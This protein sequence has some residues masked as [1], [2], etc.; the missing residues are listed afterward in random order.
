M[1]N[2]REIGPLGSILLHSPCFKILTL[3]P[4]LNRR[5]NYRK[6]MYHSAKLGGLLGHYTDLV[7]DTL[8]FITILNINGGVKPL[9]EFPTKFTSI[10]VIFLWSSI[11]LPLLISSIHLAKNNY[12]MI[13]SGCNLSIM[14]KTKS[15]LLKVGVVLLSVFNPII[16]LYSFENLKEKTRLEAK[17]MNI[18]SLS[19]NS[20]QIIKYQFVEFLSI[21]LTLE[22]VYELFGQTILF[23]LSNS[24]TLTTGGLNEFFRRDTIFGLPIEVVLTFSIIWSLK[25]LI[26]LHMKTISTEKGFLPFTSKFS[27]FLWGTVATSKRISSMVAFFIPSLGLFNILYHWKAE[28]IPFKRR[29]ML[30]KEVSDFLALNKITENVQWSDINTRWNLELYNMTEKVLWSDIDRWNFDD[31]NHPSPPGYN[32]YTGLTL[33]QSFMAFVGIFVVHFLLILIVKSFTIDHF[34]LRNHYNK[35]VHILKN[36]NI[37]TPWQDWDHDKCSVEQYKIK[38]RRVNIEMAVT[39]LVNMIISLLMICPLFYLG[40][41]NINFLSIKQL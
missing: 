5:E 33:G 17:K 37:A 32:L 27:I 31:L 29:K 40:Q 26:L 15:F 13:Y 12:Q 34:W 11:M 28:L 20:F 36:M 14:T 23:F 30:R 4:P 41:Q 3:R 7:K 16:L 39:M 19:V 25:I 8:L 2:F 18:L 10:I 21:D 22:C 38:H 6:F 35:F 24:E 9:L 1:Q